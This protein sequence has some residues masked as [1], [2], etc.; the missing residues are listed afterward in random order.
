MTEGSPYNMER[1]SDM[2]DFHAHILP[3]I[4][5]GSRSAEESLEMLRRLYDSGVRTVAATPHFYPWE[6][7]PEGFLSDREAALEKLRSL[8]DRDIPE[9]LVGAEVGYFPGM[10]S[11]EHLRDLRLSGTKF[12]L[13]E[14]P[15]ERWQESAIKELGKMACSASVIPVAAHI[16]RYFGYINKRVLEE[17]SDNGVLF[18]MNCDA[19]LDGRTRRSAVRMM[20]KGLVSF[21]GTDCHDTENR[22]PRMDEAEKILEKKLGDGFMR[23]FSEKQADV[24]ASGTV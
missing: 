7:S 17:L 3:G 15:M 24:F 23:W 14:M 20:K 12:L 16:D 18:Q 2:I 19:F 11:S 13:V 21:L 1:K 8:P 6:R 10:A 4:D 22:P 9:I 5:D